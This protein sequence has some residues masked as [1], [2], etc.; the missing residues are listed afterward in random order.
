MSFYR[1]LHDDNE[2]G[3]IYEPEF[4]PLDVWLEDL[5]NER[6]LLMKRLRFIEAHL[7]KHKRLRRFSLPQ[8]AK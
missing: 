1:P 7:V 8:R 5:G 2:N 3:R 4:L 6:E